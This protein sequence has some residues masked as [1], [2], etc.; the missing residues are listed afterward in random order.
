MI[1]TDYMIC[2]ERQKLEKGCRLKFGTLKHCMVFCAQNSIGIDNLQCWMGC[3]GTSDGILKN[4][5]R[6]FSQEHV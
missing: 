1:L 2:L 6:G 5:T 3:A 4:T